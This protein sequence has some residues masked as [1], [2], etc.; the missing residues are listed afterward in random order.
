MTQLFLLSLVAM[1]IAAPTLAALRSGSGYGLRW[2]LG[3]WVLFVMG[4][5]VGLGLLPAPGG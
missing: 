5:G 4:Y 1:T 2:A 3:W